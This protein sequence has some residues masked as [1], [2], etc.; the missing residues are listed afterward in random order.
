MRTTSR[1]NLTTA[2]KQI[3]PTGVEY[4]FQS[5]GDTATAI[6]RRPMKATRYTPRTLG[7][8]VD[9]DDPLAYLI[10]EGPPQRTALGNWE[11]QRTFANVPPQQ[12]DYSS[13]AIN[14]PAFPTAAFGGYWVDNTTSEG[15]VNVYG[16]AQ[17][18]TPSAYP[19]GGT[20]TLTYQTSTTAALAYDAS[21]ASI[22][23]A[24]NALSDVVSDGLTITIAN[25][26]S[27]DGSIR[28]QT[29]GSPIFSSDNWTLAVGGLTPTCLT[30]FSQVGVN[31]D[32]RL[33]TAR[34][35][36]NYNLPSHG[37][38]G[39]F[40]VRLGGAGVFSATVVDANNFTVSNNVPQLPPTYTSSQLFVRTYTPGPARIRTRRTTSFYL[41]GVTS[42]ITTPADI[43]VPDIATNDNVLLLLVCE[44]A[45]GFETY[46]A[47]PLS[48]WLSGPVYQQTIIATDMANF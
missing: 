10:A 38:T 36:I 48:R 5:L 40:F 27:T 14:K 32:F 1:D 25:L 2:E 29:S 15:T 8:T 39:T 6:Y 42:G 47:E 44:N 9:P 30:P 37:K 34:D 45:T 7:A 26:L 31:A 23:S 46:D 12:V 17:T 41:P 21:D 43:P 35:L 13:A 22:A 20:F 16:L 24:C 18:V 3:G 11:W 4:P 19:T 33:F 28:I